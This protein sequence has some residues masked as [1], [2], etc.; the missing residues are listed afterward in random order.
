MGILLVVP[1]QLPLLVWT[2]GSNVVRQRM[3]GGNHL[4]RYECV[5]WYMNIPNL[6]CLDFLYRNLLHPGMNIPTSFS[7]FNLHNEVVGFTVNLNVIFIS[8]FVYPAIFLKALWSLLSLLELG[9]H[10]WITL[11]WQAKCLFYF[12]TLKVSIGL[13]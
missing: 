10:R 5:F 8:I 2:K 1:L 7:D 4:R 9:M 6:L 11:D 13:P 3:F 12:L